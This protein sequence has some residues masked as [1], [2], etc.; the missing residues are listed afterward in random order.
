MLEHTQIDKRPYNRAQIK[1]EF[2]KD[3]SADLND[4]ATDTSQQQ[5]T[6]LAEYLTDAAWNSTHWYFEVIEEVKLETVSREIRIG[7]LEQLFVRCSN[8]SDV[9]GRLII[10]DLVTRFDDFLS[11]TLKD[12]KNQYLWHDWLFSFIDDAILLSFDADKRDSQGFWRPASEFISY[13]LVETF[14]NSARAIFETIKQTPLILK[15]KKQIIQFLLLFGGGYF[16]EETVIAIFDI[17][18]IN[19]ADL[20]ATLEVIFKENQAD[21]EYIGQFFHYNFN[22]AFELALEK[23]YKSY[24][25]Q[26]Q[27]FISQKFFSWEFIPDDF[28]KYPSKESI[29]KH[30]SN[31]RGYQNKKQYHEEKTFFAYYEKLDDHERQ[32][33]VVDH[34]AKSVYPIPRIEKK[35][36]KYQKKGSYAC[37]N[38]DIPTVIKEIRRARLKNE[39]VYNNSVKISPIRKALDK[40]RTT[41]IRINE[42][43]YSNEE[44]LLQIKSILPRGMTPSDFEYLEKYAI[45]NNND[46]EKFDLRSLLYLFHNFDYQAEIKPILESQGDSAF[47]SLHVLSSI[48]NIEFFSAKERTFITWLCQKKQLEAVNVLSTLIMNISPLEPYIPILKRFLKEDFVSYPLFIKYAEA[49]E[50]ERKVFFDETKKT[51]TKIYES[52]ATEDEILTEFGPAALFHLF[53]PQL[54]MTESSYMQHY[55][56]RETI[57][58]PSVDKALQ[59]LLYSPVGINQERTYL[60]NGVKV[61]LSHWRKMSAVVDTVARNPRKKETTQQEKAKTL[62]RLLKLSAEKSEEFDQ[63]IMTLLY[64]HHLFLGGDPL[65]TTYEA[66]PHSLR[67]YQEFIGTEVKQAVLD[68]L[69]EA[70]RAEN[71]T[72]YAALKKSFV[73]RYSRSFIPK[74]IN[75]VKNVRKYERNN[76]PKLSFAKTLLKNHISPTHLKIDDI[77]NHSISELSHLTLP[78]FTIDEDELTKDFI[79]DMITHSIHSK[80]NAEIEKF[81]REDVTQLDGKRR[82]EFLITKQREHCVAGYNMGVCVAG[83]DFLWEKENFY[84]VVILDPQVKKAFGGFHIEIIGDNL[85]L[86]GINPTLALLDGV[87]T[88]D[89]Y[90]KIILF[91]KR[92][93]NA[94]GISKILIPTEK[95]IYSNRSEIQ[96]II[97]AQNYTTTSLPHVITFSQNPSY[98]YQE[99]YIVT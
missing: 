88:L 30:I 43:E 73:S 45:E 18:G 90:K 59:H 25:V 76:D 24:F 39:F 61:N 12:T 8:Y 64:S 84:N 3:V 80:M 23:K 6:K 60:P 16:E 1:Q 38:L 28:L 79:G 53:P 41:P 99:C 4:Q 17:L 26:K 42:D 98:S 56:H 78:Q 40:E 54:A 75:L 91:T 62:S 21:D 71:P 97:L 67:V 49:T 55:V 31:L 20:A 52:E 72:E 46:P 65:P 93:A 86:P 36:K 92:V 13:V 34:L 5:I 83:D 74:L 95:E 70:Y 11:V 9:Q 85:V 10:V 77:A 96:D 15:E 89:L 2:R 57:R 48:P 94:L 63:E 47:L 50:D 58:N 87:D 32:R 14:A 29:E 66:K 51:L 37:K 35:L 68:D 81:V 27:F 22:N 7:V 69:L 82:L 44:I 19:D 33:F